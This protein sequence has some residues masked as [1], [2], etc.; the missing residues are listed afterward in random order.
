M[1]IYRLNG[2]R[3]SRRRFLQGTA[4]ATAALVAPSVWSAARAER[5][6]VAR[7]PGGPFTDGFGAAFYEPFKK[8]TGI[9][10]VGL[11]G[12]HEPTGMIKAMVETGNYTWDM[13]LLSKASHQVLVN[14]DYLEPIAPS[15]GPGPN[16]GKIPETMRTEFLM[17]TDVYA[18]LIAYREDTVGGNPPKGWRDFFDIEGVP[19]VRAL[20]KHPFDT[21]EEALLAD[22]VAPADLY[23]LDF[24]RAFRK[25]DTIKDEVAVWWTGGAQTSQL[26]KTGEVDMVPT[27][28]GRA[29]VAV[30]DGAPVKL[31]WDG[32]LWT[33]EGW[34][35]LKGTPNADLC[36]EFIEFCAQGKQ[37]ALYTPHVAYGPTAPDAYDH[38]D[39]ERAKVLP[40][41]PAYIKNMIQV[42]TDFWGEHKDTA[43]E[44]FNAWLLG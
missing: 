37:Q 43:S 26:L 33:Y 12:Q 35:I 23:P 13:S 10:V 11:Q 39:P 30:D 36:R 4:A 18:T 27:W 17:G 16:L 24:D 25:L 42:D 21:V 2:M 32:A 28:N 38:I 1:S 6:I 5:K 31:V 22:G 44:R 8:E 14:I 19:G 9:E 3:V 40:T 41:N 29:Q 15:G 7:D 20:R 34:S